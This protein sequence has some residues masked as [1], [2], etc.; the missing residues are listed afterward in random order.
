MP[1]HSM[2]LHVFLHVYAR[3]IEGKFSYMPKEKQETTK[4]LFSS[5]SLVQTK[6]PNVTDM[7][8]E[9]MYMLPFS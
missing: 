1:M 4:L 2:I 8:G 6:C 5:T 3:I 9:Y 7:V